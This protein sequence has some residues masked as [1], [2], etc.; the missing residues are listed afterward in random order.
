MRKNYYLVTLFVLLFAFSFKVSASTCKNER[1]L[2]LSSLANNVNVSYQEYETNPGAVS[3]GEGSEEFSDNFVG[4]YI[5][6][7]NLV[8]DLNVAIVREDTKKTAVVTSADMN[9]EGVIYIDAGEAGKI[10]NFNIYIRSNDSNCQNEVLKTLILTTPMYNNYSQYESCKE[11]PDFEL[12]Q[13][14]TTFDYSGMTDSTFR[15]KLDEY[16]EKKA[17][18]EKNANSPIYN[19]G[20]FLG[21]Y[22]WI[23]IILVI[24]IIIIVLVYKI[25]RKKSRLV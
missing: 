12:C 1:V 7:Y 16:K 4:H 6:I 15:A 2:E 19:I 18:E 23:V 3:G 25:K 10:K 20:K 11:N 13:E 21:T 24:A 5:T 17:E 14:F 22:W 8:D 9:D